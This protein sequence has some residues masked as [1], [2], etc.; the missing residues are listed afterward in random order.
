MLPLRYE[1]VYGILWWDTGIWK[2]VYEHN[3]NA[4]ERTISRKEATISSKIFT[5]LIATLVWVRFYVAHPVQS[6]RWYVIPLV[7]SHN[8]S[9]LKLPCS[10]LLHSYFPWTVTN[11]IFSLSIG[12][13]DSIPNQFI[14]SLR[15][16]RYLL[17]FEMFIADHS[18]ALQMLLRV[19]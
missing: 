13:R 15:A 11:K 17:R 4:M 9:L 12:W 5:S 8:I 18:R 2:L 6:V 19:I 16:D 14:N 7:S 3:C 1:I 10:N